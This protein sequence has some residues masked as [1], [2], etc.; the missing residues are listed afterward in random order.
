[1]TDEE[2][3]EMFGEVCRRIAEGESLRRICETPGMRSVPTVLRWIG[4][5]PAFAE[6]YARA[7]EAQADGFA[8]EIVQIADTEEDPNRARVR[9]EARKWVAGKLRPK[10]YGDRVALGGADDMPPIRTEDSGAARLAAYLDA[11]A[12]RSGTASGASG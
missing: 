6:Q 9:I 10:V 8:D 4:D 7:R 12:E 5:S 1:M 2:R 3:V 11:I